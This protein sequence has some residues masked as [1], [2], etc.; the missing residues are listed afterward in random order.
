MV[1]SRFHDAFDECLKNVRYKCKVSHKVLSFESQDLAK[2]KH[3]LS[4]ERKGCEP[5][6]PVCVQNVQ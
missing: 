1:V 2:L 6:N 4:E 5:G 3:M